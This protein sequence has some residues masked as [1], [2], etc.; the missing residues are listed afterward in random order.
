MLDKNQHEIILINI[1]KDIYSDNFLASRLGFKGGTACYLFYDLDRCSTDL[2]FNFLG[3][4][5]EEKIIIEKITQLAGK[6]GNIEES[7]TRKNTLFFLLSYEKYKQKIKIE[8]SR[9]NFD[10]EYEL[11]N[12]F[13]ISI[14]VM[15]RQNMFTHKL[16]ALTDRPKI[17]NRDL[18]DLNWYLKNNPGVNEKIIEKRTGRK[19]IAYLKYLIRFIKTKVK[20]EY[21]LDGLGEVLSGKQKAA[22]K[23]NL[24]KDLL[25][26]LN[27][28]L[29]VLSKNK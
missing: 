1:L 19:L 15:K 9:R 26:S 12:Y 18:Y 13:G 11:K 10:D 16:V 14:L 6:Y 17:A 5:E 28:Y 2:D 8:I 4:P 25:F 7:A 23:N 24:K 21:I 27:I 22:V 3:K 29:N 20:N